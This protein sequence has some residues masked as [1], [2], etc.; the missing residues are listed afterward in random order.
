MNDSLGLVEVEGYSTSIYIA[1]TM[2]KTAD[3]S[4]DKIERAKGNGW[5]TIYISGDVGAVNAA[6]A[7]G[8]DLA[9]QTDKLVSFKVIARPAFDP[10]KF[11]VKEIAKK[12]EP[13]A[14]N[15]NQKNTNKTK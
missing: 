14:Q 1:D 10:K 3:I 12:V 6:I 13:K 9:E 7:A 11:G 2:V 5:M 4:I 15:N 8:Q